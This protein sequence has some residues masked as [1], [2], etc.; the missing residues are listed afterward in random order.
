MFKGL[1]K[2]VASR[3]KYLQMKRWMNQRASSTAVKLALSGSL[4]MRI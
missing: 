2:W 1:C 3:I 4:R